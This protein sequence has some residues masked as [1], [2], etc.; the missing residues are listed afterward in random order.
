MNIKGHPNRKIVFILPG[1]KQIYTQMYLFFHLFF[2]SYIFKMATPYKTPK[3]QKLEQKEVY[4][5]AN[6]LDQVHIPKNQVA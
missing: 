6:M 3:E 4:H 2:A 1:Y 5:T